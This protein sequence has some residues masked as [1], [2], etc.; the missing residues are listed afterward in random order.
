MVIQQEEGPK[1][2]CKKCKRT[3][4]VNELKREGGAWVCFSCYENLHFF[5]QAREKIMKQKGAV[6]EPLKEEIN[7]DK[8][9]KKSTSKK[10]VRKY[11]CMD[12]SYNFMSSAFNDESMCP[13]CG[14]KGT[15]KWIQP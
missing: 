13:F 1:V 10:D 12:C 3:V 6:Q 14:E 11:Q 7:V 4:L 8:I 2:V 9:I 15:A 5:E